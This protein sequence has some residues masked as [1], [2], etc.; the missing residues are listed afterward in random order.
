MR[1]LVIFATE[2]EAAITIEKMK[3]SVLQD[4]PFKILSDR[5]GNFIL[6]CGIGKM[7]V[8]I[9]GGYF[10]GKYEVDEIINIGA[11]GALTAEAEIGN[12]YSPATVYDLS[13]FAR[14][15]QKYLIK[16]RS[17]SDDSTILSV[18]FPVVSAIDRE[19][20]SAY[21]TLVDMESAAIVQLA[22]RF[23]LKCSLIKIVSDFTES[24]HK[25]IVDNIKALSVKFY[26]ELKMIV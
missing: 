23:R 7:S 25:E 22:N 3:F 15:P 5:T 11:A 26:E 9:A 6:I 10:L 16:D 12:V 2:I 14:K 17:Y 24:N 4:Y 21:S 1:R 19:I 20:L 8:S 13:D 18:N